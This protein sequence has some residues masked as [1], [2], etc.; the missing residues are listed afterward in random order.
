ERVSALTPLCRAA[1]VLQCAG[2]GRGVF[3]HEASGSQWPTG[4]SG[5]VIW[6][7]VPMKHV[8][9]ALG[10]PID[11]MKYLTS[12][13]GEILPEG[14]DP[15]LVKAERSIPIEKALDDVLLAWEMNGRPIPLVHGGP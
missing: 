12:T 15:D 3:E 8:I 6:S 7:G 2:N 4:A 9:A 5:N 11:G 14:L 10:G 1:M 13:G